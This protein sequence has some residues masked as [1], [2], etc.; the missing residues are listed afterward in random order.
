MDLML[1]QHANVE[2]FHGFE[3]CAADSDMIQGN[4]VHT[5]TQGFMHRSYDWGRLASINASFYI[6]QRIHCD[7]VYYGNI[8]LE[9]VSCS[10]LSRTVSADFT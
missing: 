2:C 4:D 9:R 5:G 6:Q 10:M 7:G 3:V 1:T 8:L